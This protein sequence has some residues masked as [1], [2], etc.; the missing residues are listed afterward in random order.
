MTRKLMRPAALAGL[1]IALG[2][3]GIPQLLQAN[4][5]DDDRDDRGRPPQTLPQGFESTGRC[6]AT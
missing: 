6:C 2:S 5:R 3:L 4:D 1:F